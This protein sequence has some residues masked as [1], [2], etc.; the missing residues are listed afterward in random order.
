MSDSE[1]Q[2]K[3]YLENRERRL[4]QSKAYQ[5]EHRDEKR[6]YL[7]EYYKNNRE[8]YKKTPEQRAKHNA[9]R[10]AKYAASAE[11]RAR[12]CAEVAQWQRDN[13]EKR[14]NQRLRQYGISAE[15][16][17]KILAAQG[18]SCAICGR[19]DSGNANDT[20]LH[21]D[22]C[23]ATGKVRG[24]LCTNCNHGI[25]KFADSPERLNRAAAYLLASVGLSGK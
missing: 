24:L 18:G 17:R 1:Y 5:Q 9:A 23:H 2:R 15:D 11:V 21:V 19:I 6:E 25:G 14:L 16:Y 20:R 4:A 22:H 10:R 7:A 8:K 13:P 12:V 3:Y